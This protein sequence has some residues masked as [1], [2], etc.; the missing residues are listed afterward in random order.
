MRNNVSLDWTVKEAARA[1]IR[2]VVK[3]LL[4]KYGY[5][6]DM[7]LLATE[8]ILKQAE[9]LAGELGK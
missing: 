2:V 1:K 9:L 5:S 6:P 3:R 4:K 7:S 8:T